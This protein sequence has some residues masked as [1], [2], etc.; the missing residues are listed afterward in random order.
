MRI[1]RCRHGVTFAKTPIQLDSACHGGVLAWEE[2]AMISSS[3]AA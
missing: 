1:I 3:H 2:F